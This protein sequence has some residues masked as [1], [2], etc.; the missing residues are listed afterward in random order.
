MIF[1]SG[2]E[3]D[4]S[5]RDTGIGSGSGIFGVAENSSR[6]LIFVSGIGALRDTN[7]SIVGVAE[8]TI[9]GFGSFGVTKSS[10]FG[11]VVG[12]MIF[13]VC[14]GPGI[15]ESSSKIGNMFGFS[16][17]VGVIRTV[18]VAAPVAGETRYLDSCVGIPKWV[19]ATRA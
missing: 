17:D 5:L 2:V 16:T 19:V 14:I 9:F 10:S 6:S 3:D 13:K 15:A 11:I 18:R 4:S 8:N 12:N 1:V 7:S